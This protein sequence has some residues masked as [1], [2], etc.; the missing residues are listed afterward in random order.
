MNNLLRKKT[1]LSVL[2]IMLFV[3]ALCST[4]FGFKSSVASATTDEKTEEVIYY[5]D[6]VYGE[7]VGSATS[8]LEIFDY[9]T[10]NETPVYYCNPSF[11]SYYNTNLSL[12]NA[13]ANVAGANIIGYFDRYFENLIPACVPGFYRQTAYIYY[14]ILMNKKQRQDVIDTLYIDMM[15]NNPNPGTSQLG[16]IVGLEAYIT[17]TGRSLSAETVMT[18]GK[19]DFNKAIKQLSAGKPITLYMQGYN[20][21][22]VTDYGTQLRIDKALYNSNHI[23]IAY[24]CQKVDYYNANGSLIKSKIYLNVSPGM[25]GAADTYIVDNNGI[26]DDAEAMNIF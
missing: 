4:F 12:T 11:P 1:L 25:M 24:G 16:Y 2:A 8:D 5:G 19:F 13:C 7:A 6:N 14:P 20:T 15:T 18:N 21:V 3:V 23:M 26:L 17:R 9:A 22:T 10:K